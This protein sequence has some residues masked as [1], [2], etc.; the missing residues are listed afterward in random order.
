MYKAGENIKS[1]KNTNNINK[2]S[3]DDDIPITFKSM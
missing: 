2:K 3:S 1:S